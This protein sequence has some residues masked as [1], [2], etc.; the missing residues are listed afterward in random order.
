VTFLLG[1]FVGAV[2]TFAADWIVEGRR[3]AKMR[4]EMKIK[5]KRYEAALRE[6]EQSS[7]L[8]AAVAKQKGEVK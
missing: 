4:L 2:L 7:A 8:F 1:L 5:N 3:L 6:F